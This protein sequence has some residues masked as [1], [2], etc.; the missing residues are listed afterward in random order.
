MFNSKISVKMLFSSKKME[1]TKKLAEFRGKF[2]I[3]KD[4]HVR[5]RIVLKITASVFNLI[6]LAGT[7][8]SVFVVKTPL[9]RGSL[10]STIQ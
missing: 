3:S 9:R 4:A 8:V 2:S 7:Y 5:N 10:E 1:I 6:F